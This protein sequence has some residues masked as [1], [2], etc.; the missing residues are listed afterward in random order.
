MTATNTSNIQSINVMGSHGAQN[1]TATI[2][3]VNTSLN[4]GDSVTID[5]GYSDGHSVV[6]TG[7]VKGIQKSEQ[8]IQYTITAIDT[9]IRAMD[10][11]I[12]SSTP[13]SPFTRQ[14]ISAENLIGDI[15]ALSGITNYSGAASYFTLG[16]N[17][18][19]EVN[20]T[21]AYDYCKFV[22]DLLAWHL[23]SD[24]N[25]KVWFLDR[26]PY[27]MGGDVS[28]KTITL[29]SILSANYAEDAN[30][31]RNRVVMYG[32][33]G[34]AAEASAVSPYLPAGFYKSA[35]V[36]ASIIDSQTYADQCVAYNL[37]LYNRLTRSVSMSVEGD[38]TLIPRRVLT[39]STG[40]SELDYEWYIYGA[41]HSINSGGFTTDLELRR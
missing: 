4:L 36:S 29:P 31:L 17:N 12:V 25:G 10:Y 19:I 38:S 8:P 2:E 28:Y 40:L 9:L 41:S 20:L 35:V 34:I 33:E 37:N 11:F 14:N 3:A 32:A 30:N 23:Y 13:E 26:K 18:P 27:I 16:I 1:A 21:S 39:L 5:L 24:I 6:F 22:T 15:L 7:L